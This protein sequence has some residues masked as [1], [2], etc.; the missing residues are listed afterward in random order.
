MA[1]EQ[2]YPEIHIQFT[3]NETKVMLENWEAAPVQA[4]RLDTAIMLINKE[5]L[6]R[7]S[8]LV[9]QSHQEKANA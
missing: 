2:K 4:H 6:R 7:R 1:K 8:Q 5:I 9:T 3:P